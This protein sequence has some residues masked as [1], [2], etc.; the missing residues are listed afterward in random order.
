MQHLPDP[1][2]GLHIVFAYKDTPL[3]RSLHQ[4]LDAA[5]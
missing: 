5:T 4:L 3:S 1:R 2:M